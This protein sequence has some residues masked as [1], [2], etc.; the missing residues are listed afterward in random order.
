MR[1]TFI[2]IAL[3][4][5]ITAG[6]ALATDARDESARAEVLAAENARTAALVQHHVVK[7]VQPPLRM[8]VH[9]AHGLRMIPGCRQ[10]AR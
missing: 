8:M 7:P 9:L 2:L 3:L 4:S 1:R 5:S 6:S 10:P